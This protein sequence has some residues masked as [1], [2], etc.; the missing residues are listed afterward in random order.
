MKPPPVIYATVNGASTQVI[1]PQAGQRGLIG[2]WREHETPGRNE[3]IYYRADALVHSQAVQREIA[4]AIQGLIEAAKEAGLDAMPVS[5]MESVVA[6][7]V[8][9]L[10]L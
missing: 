3:A 5:T 7:I 1:G 2:G 6:E 9:G 4:S 10:P 8:A